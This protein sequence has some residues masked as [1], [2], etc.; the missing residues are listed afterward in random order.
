MSIDWENA[1]R[2]FANQLTL[3]P[4]KKTPLRKTPDTATDSPLRS[5][6]PSTP[7]RP[8][9]LCLDSAHPSTLLSPA[10]PE[11]VKIFEKSLLVS[12]CKQLKRPRDKPSR[13]AFTEYKINSAPLQSYSRIIPKC[14]F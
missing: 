12:P 13:Y 7:T 5:Q 8:S 1:R 9:H 4:L 2:I 11:I 14:I 3:S 10:D 6:Q